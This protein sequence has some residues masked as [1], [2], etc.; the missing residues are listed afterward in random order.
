MNLPVACVH[1]AKIITK[2][3]AKSNCAYQKTSCSCI[4]IQNGTDLACNSCACATCMV[5]LFQHNI[6][7]VLSNKLLTIL[8]KHV[9]LRE[10][11]KRMKQPLYC[12]F[13]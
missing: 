1:A 11:Q 13:F 2:L 3:H 12:F 9:G 6:V 10:G 8:S 4:M 7:Y 5:S